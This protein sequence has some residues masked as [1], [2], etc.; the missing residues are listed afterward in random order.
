M[1]RLLRRML[2]APA[3]LFSSAFNTADADMPP[4][5]PAQHTQC[6]RHGVRESRTRLAQHSVAARQDFRGTR[7]PSRFYCNRKPPLSASGQHRFTK[8]PA[9]I[10][11][12]KAP[13]N[14]LTPPSILRKL[15][16][17]NRWGRGKFV[18]KLYKKE[19]SLSGKKLIRTSPSP[20]SAANICATSC[21]FKCRPAFTLLLEKTH[22]FRH[23]GTG[24]ICPIFG[25][26]KPVPICLLGVLDRDP[27]PRCR[28]I[29]AIFAHPH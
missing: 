5:D 20:P 25:Q 21:P 13:H 6:P 18:N 23:L 4:H 3:R 11:K 7:L 26:N 29:C 2:L 8:H 9:P 12:K 10:F 1:T 15:A 19:P 17:L 16:F 14:H 24:L 27:L 28:K 22:I